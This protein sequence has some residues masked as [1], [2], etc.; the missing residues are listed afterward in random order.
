MKK[1]TQET[2]IANTV[3]M[4]KETKGIDTYCTFW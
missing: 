1:L 2:V 4:W 3:K